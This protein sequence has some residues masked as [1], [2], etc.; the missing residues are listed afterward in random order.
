MKRLAMIGLM[1]G[2]MLLLAGAAL[3]QDRGVVIVTGQSLPWQWQSPD[4]VWAPQA[5]GTVIPSGYSGGYG[6]YYSGGYAGYSGYG[7][8]FGGEIS[9]GEI[10]TSI[11]PLERCQWVKIN[12]QKYQ[13]CSG[14]RLRIGH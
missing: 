2:L 7:A 11:I 1:I 4:V 13:T 6:G 14:S 10:I 8:G 5:G 12:G 9:L 3:S